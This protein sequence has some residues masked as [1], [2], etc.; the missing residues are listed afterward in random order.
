M[1][2][3]V[4]VCTAKIGRNQLWFSSEMNTDIP[5]PLKVSV[6]NV[7]MSIRA[8]LFVCLKTAVFFSDLAYKYCWKWSPKTHLSRVDILENTVFAVLVGMDE[9]GS[10]YKRLRYGGCCVACVEDTVYAMRG[11]AATQARYCIHNNLVPRALFPGFGGGA[12]KE[13]FRVDGQ[14]RFKNG[15]CGGELFFWKMGTC[16]SV[17]GLYIPTDFDAQYLSWKSP[18]YPPQGMISSR[19]CFQ[20]PSH[21]R[22]SWNRALLLE[23]CLRFDV[24]GNIFPKTHKMKCPHCKDGVLE[25][26]QELSLKCSK[27]RATFCLSSTP[28]PQDNNESTTDLSKQGVLDSNVVVNNKADSSAGK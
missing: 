26:D 16:G 18:T 3:G 20:E 13:G 1:S 25:E 4:G 12:G 15:T 28:V 11:P 2:E 9:N 19:R 21:F 22:L 24:E 23:R 8:H 6:F 5:N 17:D 14:K 27:C 10:F 7:F